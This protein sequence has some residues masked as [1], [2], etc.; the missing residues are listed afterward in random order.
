MLHI[1]I[2]IYIYIY[3]EREKAREGERDAHTHICLEELSEVS[4]DLLDFVPDRRGQAWP[5]T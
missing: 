2:Y 4:E 1:Y 3:R 5:N